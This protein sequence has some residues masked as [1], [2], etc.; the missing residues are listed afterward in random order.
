MRKAEGDL[1]GLDRWLSL[2]DTQQFGKCIRCKNK[3][4]IN[5]LLLMPASTRC[6]HCAKL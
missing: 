2:Y 5:R 1:H 6:I 4:N 3:I